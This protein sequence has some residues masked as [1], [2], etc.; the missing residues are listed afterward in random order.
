MSAGREIRWQ[1]IEMAATFANMLSVEEADTARLLE[2]FKDIRDKPHIL[3]SAT[4]DRV[5]ARC[6]SAL[7]LASVHE[8]QIE[9]WRATKMSE[10]DRRHVDAFASASSRNKALVLELQ[11][12]AREVSGG[13]INEMMGMSDPELGA[14]L[15]GGKLNLP[16]QR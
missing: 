2:M 11:A 14:A 6:D 3:D 16:K 4:V 9:R 15:L 8:Q 1:P 5:L 13:T 10:T 12:I 7:E